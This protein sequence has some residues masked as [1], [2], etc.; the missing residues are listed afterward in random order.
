MAIHDNELE[1]VRASLPEYIK[2]AR[3]GVE[4]GGLG[5]PTATLL[6]SVIDAIGSYHRKRAGY[7][8]KIDGRDVEILVTD[9][10]FRILNSHYFGKPNGLGLTGAQINRVYLRARCPVTHNAAVGVGCLLAEGGTRDKPIFDEKGFSWIH[11]PTL[12]ERCTAAVDAFLA[13]APSIIPGS[14]VAD[15]LKH[16]IPKEWKEAYEALLNIPAGGMGS[17][18]VTGNATPPAMRAINPIATQRPTS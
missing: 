5:C 14:E 1:M 17:I 4:Q 16:G 6:F 8:V 3:A 7:T 12:L 11:L 10:H 2:L 18:S 13:E 9:D 15:R